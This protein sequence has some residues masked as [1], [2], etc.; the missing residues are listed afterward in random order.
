[1]S[2]FSGSIPPVSIKVKYL[3]NHSTS[4]NI[5]SLVTPGV[6]STIDIL[7]PANL[8]NRVDFPTFGLPTTATMGLLSILILLPILSLCLPRLYLHLTWN[9]FNI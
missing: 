8:L 3:F 2:S 9:Y 6:S 1:M 7:F 4:V 5:L